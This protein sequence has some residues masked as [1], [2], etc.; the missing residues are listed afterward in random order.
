MA[1]TSYLKWPFFE[2]HH[3]RLAQ[4][5]DAWARQNIAHSHGS[6]VDAECRQLVKALGEAGWLRHA[7][8]GTAYGGAGEHIDTRAICLI[9][10]TL[11]RHSGLA[12]FAFAMQGLGSGAISLA[13]SEEQKKRYLSLVARGDAI[14]A[15]A[16]SEPDAGSDVAAMACEARLEGDHYVI[17]GEKTWISNGGIAD[18]YVVFVRTGEAAGSRGLS[19]LIVEAG[20]PGFEIAE[21][22]NVIAPH[23]LARLKFSNCRVPAAQ[24][25]GAAGEGFKVA[26]R[27]L[28]VFRTSVAAASLGFARRAMDEALQRATSRKMFGGVLAD[29][30]VTQA[31]LAQMATQIDSAALLTYR[32]AWL[33]D[34]GENVTREAAMAKMTATENAQQVIDAAVQ[35]WGGLGVV[36]EQP[37]ERL[38]REIRALR[39][40]EGATEVQQL[41]IGRDLIKSHS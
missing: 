33:R 30:Q 22:I 2:A 8:A 39:I 26:M 20:T 5:L 3:A 17:N 15:F 7:V 25:V 35:I 28:D 38:Y 10:E 34:Q 13:G 37:V 11:A 29:F 41:I 9:R 24:L 27:T 4:S 23:P 6:D 18:F 36:S 12:D 31:K 14:S 21:R 19:A 40:Y 16:L 1:D 32:A